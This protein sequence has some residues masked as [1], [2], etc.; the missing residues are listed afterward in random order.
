MAVVTRFLWQNFNQLGNTVFNASSTLSGRSAEWLRHQLRSKTWRS[1]SGWSFVKG[2]NDVLRF[3]DGTDKRLAYVTGEYSTGALAAAAVESAMDAAGI[4][5]TDLSPS[6]WL[7]ADSL[8]LKDG[9]DVT[10]WADSSGNGNNLDTSVGTQTYYR[11]SLNGRPSVRFDEDGYLY[12]AASAVQMD[13]LLDGS[14]R[15]TVFVVGWVD[16]DHTAPSALWAQADDNRGHFLDSNDYGVAR[17]YDGSQDEAQ[18]SAESVG[19][20]KVFC[21][22][23]DGTNVENYIDD[24]DDAAVDGQTASGVQTTL[25]QDFYLGSD[26]ANH[27]PGFICELLVVPGVV[28][29]ETRRRVVQTLEQKYELSTDTSAATFTNTYAVSYSSSTFKFTLARDTGAGAFALPWTEAAYAGRTLGLDLGFDTS[30]DDNSATSYAADNAVYQSRHFVEVDLGSALSVTSSCVINHNAGDGG[31]FTIEA[32]DEPW[33]EDTADYTD[34]LAASNRPE[35]IR[36]LFFTE[37]QKRFWR[38]VIDDRTNADGY[39]EVG[40]WYLGSY[41]QPNKQHLGGFQ[42]TREELSQI[43]LSDHGAAFFDDRPTLK[44]WSLQFRPVIATDKTQFET[45]LDYVKTSRPFFLA[46]D[47]SDNPDSTYYVYLSAGV[48]INHIQ[49]SVALYDVAMDV[50]RA[51]L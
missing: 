37:Q 27:L 23:Y 24:L 1:A 30:A 8:Q 28:T 39:S 46:L 4:E 9:D 32:N 15:G 3:V 48:S 7:K 45:M 10:A 25:T 26:G 38:L 51:P 44:G 19:A 18:G 20:W 36:I 31:T 47:A 50:L 14:G 40:I 6:L 12:A 35:D 16:S 13:D 42:A 43:G 22:N 41:F 33:W 49:S 5:P 21:W 11:E 34:D 2:F 29:E 17:A